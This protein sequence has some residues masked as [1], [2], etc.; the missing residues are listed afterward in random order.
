MNLWCKIKERI[1]NDR[2]DEDSERSKSL[3]YHKNY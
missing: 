2:Y 1:W 3:H